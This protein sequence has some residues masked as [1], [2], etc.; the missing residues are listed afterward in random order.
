MGISSRHFGTNWSWNAY[1]T[2]LN[3]DQRRPLSRVS[4]HPWWGSGVQSINH[5]LSSLKG[6]WRWEHFHSTDTHWGPEKGQGELG[7]ETI[8][9]IVDKS[10][11]YQSWLR[12]WVGPYCCCTSSSQHWRRVSREERKMAWWKG[13]LEPDRLARSASCKI[14]CQE[15]E[16]PT[17]IELPT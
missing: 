16:S 12:T 14:L 11:K 4:D 17:Q 7:E 10:H 1:Q 8:Q 13:L 15:I 6:P 9:S 3:K 5:E 2:C